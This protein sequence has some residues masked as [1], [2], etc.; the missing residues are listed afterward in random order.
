MQ[1]RRRPR[2]LLL[3]VTWTNMQSGLRYNRANKSP[4]PLDGHPTLEKMFAALQD[5]LQVVSCARVQRRA[6]DNRAQ[7]GTMVHRRASLQL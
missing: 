5:S 4:H 2:L 1:Q 7:K 3:P 6:A